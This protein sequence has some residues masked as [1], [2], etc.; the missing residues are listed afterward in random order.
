MHIVSEI[1]GRK[2]LL[3]SL[4]R[5]ISSGVSG[6]NG[7]NVE[8]MMLCSLVH[9]VTYWALAPTAGTKAQIGPGSDVLIKK[10]TDRRGHQRDRSWQEISLPFG[11]PVYG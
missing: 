5:E 11:E 1:D 10:A 8:A 7:C 2:L 4:T 6:S 3:L 9:L